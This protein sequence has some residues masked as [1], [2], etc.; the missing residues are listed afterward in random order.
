MR[1]NENAGHLV[2]N[3]VHNASD[4]RSDA[5]KTARRG[6]HEDDPEA[7]ERG[8]KGED[9]HQVEAR[10]G[11]R[12]VTCKVDP[13]RYTLCR[14]SLQT[15]PTVRTPAGRASAQH[16]ATSTSSAGRA[17]FATPYRITR[18]RSSGR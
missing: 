15:V 7:L 5:R 6:L 16:S 12:S 18:T 17:G 8:G 1:R 3:G 13:L 2:V 9:V 14:S 11:V 10:R 4:S